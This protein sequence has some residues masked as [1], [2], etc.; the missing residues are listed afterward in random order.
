MRCDIMRNSDDTNRLRKKRHGTLYYI[1]HFILCNTYK[2][3]YK[4]IYISIRN[5][6]KSGFCERTRCRK[7]HFFS[8][9]GAEIL[10]RRKRETLLIS[11]RTKK[12]RNVYMYILSKVY[13]I[14]FYFIF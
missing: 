8:E 2:Y 1:I 14:M 6:L 13:R 7:S 5:Y 12:K 3:T 10:K 4:Y 9:R 11:R